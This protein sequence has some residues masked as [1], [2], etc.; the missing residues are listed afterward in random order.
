M[1]QLAPGFVG[2]L[3]RGVPYT[4]EQKNAVGSDVQDMAGFGTRRR[5][6]NMT[7]LDA[8]NN[9]SPR[10][11][12]GTTLSRP[13]VTPQPEAGASLLPTTNIDGMAVPSE[14]AGL[15]IPI[16]QPSLGMPNAPV[17]DTVRDMRAYKAK[18]EGMP[19]PRAVAQAE[20][21]KRG[22]GGKLL[23][24]LRGIGA[25]GQRGGLLGM[26]GGGVSGYQGELREQEL[27]QKQ[28]LENDR[29]RANVLQQF[30]ISKAIADQEQSEAMQDMEGR[31]LDYSNR[32]LA[33]KT[34]KNA[35]DQQMEQAK[36]ALDEKVR[37]GQ[38][39]V[40]QAKVQLENIRN[41]L[42]A[43]RNA[44]DLQNQYQ[45]TGIAIP[46]G[47]N[48]RLG[49]A[50]GFVLP[51]RPKEQGYN[52][53]EVT[54][55]DGNVSLYNRN[56]ADPRG[57]MVNTGIIANTNSGQGDIKEAELQ[58]RAEQRA[59][60]E[61]N[62]ANPGGRRQ[63]K[64]PRYDE[65]TAKAA[66]DP[67]GKE[68]LALLQN[69]IPEFLEFTSK[70]DPVLQEQIKRYINEGRPQRTNSRTVNA[71]N[72][73]TEKSPRQ[74]VN[75]GTSKEMNDR[76]NQYKNFKKN[77]KDPNDPRLAAMRQWLEARGYKE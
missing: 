58:S 6:T 29:T 37:T 16:M 7:A 4:G 1:A 32:E 24:T 33:F 66:A 8:R 20:V 39:S 42:T 60:E 40:D 77:S 57:S 11:Q 52:W 10:A 55:Q 46:A 12:A 2:E 56:A 54:D 30:N 63:I 44:I 72:T 71:A 41:Q 3:G 31:K 36:Y 27:M 43:E 25:G 69:Q 18:L 73:P 53:Q 38:L 65:Y 76:V 13:T 48:T 45:G 23:D 67:T 9:I 21:A 28:Q 75:V 34:D 64:N 47:M 68:A 49:Q 17:S 62:K 19:D 50:P 14:R 35:F 5:R 61:W 74:Q 26:I 51:N 22:F 15:K 70:N 59:L